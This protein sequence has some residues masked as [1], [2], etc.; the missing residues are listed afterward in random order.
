MSEERKPLHGLVT[1]NFIVGYGKEV[2]LSGVNLSVLPGQVVT[3]IGPNGSG[4]ST[5][6]KSLTRQLEGLGGTAYLGGKDMAGMKEH[7]V[8][9]AMAMVMTERVKP[10]LMTCR[11]MVATGR[12]PYTGRLGIL[13]EEDWAIVDDA[14]ASVHAEAVADQDFRKI[15]D[16]Q[17]QRIMLAR[18]LC[19]DTAVLVLDEPTS[20]LDLK[21]KLDILGTIRRLAREKNLA[22][23]MS[24]HE[25]ELA[26]QVADCV[27]CVDGE[28][29]DRIGSPE[30][31]F[32]G[33]YI[34]KLYQIPEEAF[35]PATC[36]VNLAAYD[37]ATRRGV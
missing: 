23:I 30:E 16:G 14:I 12:Y 25:L 3:L 27:V 33:N 21:F 10:E 19:Q 5:L 1:D 8:A 31:I 18:A 20:Y 22:I 6:L 36:S 7:E 29:I 4:K 28:K 13:S 35:D 24:L 17:R 37:R 34:Q 9:C 32:A 2:V 11:D 26:K 15:S